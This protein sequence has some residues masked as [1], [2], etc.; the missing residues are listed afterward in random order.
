MTGGGTASMKKLDDV[1]FAYDGIIEFKPGGRHA[2][3]FGIASTVKPGGALPLT[4][5]F[6]NAP[7]ITVS[8]AVKSAAGDGGEEHAEH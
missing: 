8:A 7:P 4:F 3:L 2:M 1:D 6:D 5:A